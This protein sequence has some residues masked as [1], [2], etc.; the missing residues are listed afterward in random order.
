MLLKE[1]GG[2]SLFARTG[3]RQSPI[4]DFRQFIKIRPTWYTMEKYLGQE[5]VRGA[6]GRLEGKLLNESRYDWVSH[7]ESR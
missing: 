3:I 4:F 6:N 2:L 7:G 1:R 5:E